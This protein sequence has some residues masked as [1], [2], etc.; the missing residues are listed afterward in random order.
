MSL[1][2]RVVLVV[3]ALVASS[4]VTGAAS[5]RSRCAGLVGVLPGAVV[6][7][8][9]LVAASDTEGE[10]CDVRGLVAPRIRFHLKLPT[11]YSGRYLQLGCGGFCGELAPPTPRACG[12]VPGDL[13]VATT[14]DGHTGA[15]DVPSVD[16]SW[17]G[18]RQAR[19]DWQFRAPHVVSRTAKDVIARY[20]GA[21]PTFSYFSGCSGGGREA[22]LLAQRHPEAFDGIAAGAPAVQLSA[23]IVHQ[24]WL[25]RVTTDPRGNP[26]LTADRLPGLHA[27]VLARCDHLD[28]LTDGQLDDPRACDFDPAAL[29]CPAGGAAC[30][31]P[32]QVEAVRKLYDGPRTPDGQRLHPAGQARGSEL[33]WNRWIVPTAEGALAARLA[34]QYL[35]H[36]AHPLGAPH[37][38]LADFRFT[39]AEFHRLTAEGLRA[40]AMSTDLTAF[41]RAGGKL[42]MW[43]GWGDE[44][45][46]AAGLLD[47]HARLTARYPRGLSDWARVFMVPSLH[48]CGRGETLTSFDP[49]PDL[50]R[51]TEHGAAPDRITAHGH[52]PN[53]TPR[54]RPVFPYPLRAT[55]DGT[56]STDD[57]ANF[58][59]TPPA[60]PPRDAVD[61][62][63]A[64]LHRLPGPVG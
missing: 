35:R 12:T 16:A 53:G 19:D 28:G 38:T 8:A 50:I 39:A 60:T 6:T 14:D 54:S 36:L 7:D 63:G 22:L 29:L 37:T 4:V 25:A 64:H 58:T 5:T 46:P 52:A 33:A 13:A 48:H 61:W 55:Y 34:D 43:H 42:L 32:A 24:A 31:T 11:D 45:I 56:G 15:G 17:A 59:P 47:Y 41:H 1:R 49:L 21:P 26:V 23:L 10:H 40:N 3:V 30:L 9:A 2:A 18:D 57:A 44:A 27:A 20:Y 51:W 62:L